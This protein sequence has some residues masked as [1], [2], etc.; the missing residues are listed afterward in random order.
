MRMARSA[1]RPQRPDEV[2]AGALLG[3][4]IDI[5]LP[6]SPPEEGRRCLWL[7]C[8]VSEGGRASR[9]WPSAATWTALVARRCDLWRRPP[10]ADGDRT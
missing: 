3:L 4:S 5:W 6:A 1:V 9:E 7:G 2:D 8:S 10:S